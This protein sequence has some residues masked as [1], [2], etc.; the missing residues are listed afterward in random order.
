[1]THG[2]SPLCSPVNTQTDQPFLDG[3]STKRERLDSAGRD[4]MAR[5]YTLKHSADIEMS[6]QLANITTTTRQTTGWQFAPM[7]KR[8]GKW[9]QLANYG[10]GRKRELQALPVTVQQLL[11][12]QQRQCLAESLAARQCRIV[13]TSST[14]DKTVL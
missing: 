2:C 12:R 6:C 4:K 10:E 5:K 14:H 7:E 8:D 3:K 11:G 9:H 1:M 13:H